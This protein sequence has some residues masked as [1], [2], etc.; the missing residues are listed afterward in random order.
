MYPHH[1]EQA[2]NILLQR[3]VRLTVRMFYSL[4]LNSYYSYVPIHAVASQSND[5]SKNEDD[6]HF[7]IFKNK[8]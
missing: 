6:K 7:S 2:T 5:E 4:K 1:K 3:N 8:V